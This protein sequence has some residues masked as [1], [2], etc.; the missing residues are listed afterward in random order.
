MTNIRFLTGIGDVLIKITQ[1]YLQRLP[2]TVS[3][4][5]QTFKCGWKQNKCHRCE[6]NAKRQF[7]YT[8]TLADNQYMNDQGHCT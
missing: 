6:T 8:V 7:I 5:S 2:V 4:F 3:I 1:K